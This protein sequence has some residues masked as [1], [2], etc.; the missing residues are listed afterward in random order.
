MKL[1]EEKLIEMYRTMV[2]IRRFESSL[3]E[4]V[5]AGVLPG[6]VHLGVGQEGVMAGVAYALEPDDW[7][8]ST[9][10]EHGM[11][12][13]RGAEL[14]RCRAEIFG[15]ATG[16]CKGKGGSMHLAVLD[17]HCTGCNGI[18][19]PSQTIA[20]GIAF[21][22]KYNQTNNVS[23]VMFG[24]GAAERGEFHEAMNLAA[25]WKLPTLFCCVNNQYGISLSSKLSSAVEDIAARGVSYGIPGLVV[26]GNDVMAVHEALTEAAKRARAGEGPSLIELKTARQRGHFEGDP[27]PYRTPEEKEE[28]LRNDPIKRFEASL[29][30]K[31]LLTQKRI[32]DIWASVEADLQAA[33]RFTDESPYPAFEEAT[34]DVFYT[35]V[36]A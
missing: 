22:L 31:K 18:L 4:A 29:L 25:I 35:E 26:D 1:S 9:H 14:G 27:E 6:F 16:Y 11:L 2:V 3:A 28:V 20:N 21:A 30:D 7:V 15:K 36:A 5:A 32:Q 33:I 13:A 17:K 23:V 24:D 8:S 34:T 19:G 10:R 12:I